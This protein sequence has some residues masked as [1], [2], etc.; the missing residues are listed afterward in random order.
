[1][2]SHLIIFAVVVLIGQWKPLEFFRL[3]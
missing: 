2:A 1:M 3:E